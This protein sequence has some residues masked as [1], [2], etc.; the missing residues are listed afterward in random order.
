MNETTQELEKSM[1]GQIVRT[2]AVVAAE[3][4][5]L[6]NQTRVMVLNNSIE[7]GKRLL[8]AKTMV[9]HGE[10]G[11]W[12]ATK[13]HYGQSTAENLIRIYREYGNKQ[14]ELWGATAASST[15]GSLT[16]TKALALL[17]VPAEEREDFAKEVKAEDL[18]TRELQ[19][20]IAARKQAEIDKL[21]AEAQAKTARDEWEAADKLRKQAEAAKDTAEKEIAQLNKKL[22]E[23]QTGADSAETKKL[24]KELKEARQ[25]AETKQKALEEQITSLESKAKSIDEVVKAAVKKEREAAEQEITKLKAAAARV[26]VPTDVAAVNHI[27]ALFTQYQSIFNAI[28]RELAAI[29]TAETKNKYAGALTKCNEIFNKTLAK[30]FPTA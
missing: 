25:A 28:T 9:K 8:E 24:K 5:Q 4:N 2:P 30:D 29:G 23:A 21:S 3:I 6:T 14:G 15:L 17:A 16:Y 20:E 22:T 27:E 19:A 7:I 26:A 12:L 18:S 1:E 10:W 13:V 11:A